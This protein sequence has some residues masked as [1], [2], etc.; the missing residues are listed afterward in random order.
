MLCKFINRDLLI[1]GTF[2]ISW[3]FFYQLDIFDQV[4][5]S[6]LIT[7]NLRWLF[8]HQSVEDPKVKESFV[9]RNVWIIP[10]LI[11]RWSLII[12]IRFSSR[13]K[14]GCTHHKSAQ[15]Q[16][17]WYFSK[18]HELR[19]RNSEVFGKRVLYF[20]KKGKSMEKTSELDLKQLN[21]LHYILI[22]WQRYSPWS[23]A[24]LVPSSA[25]GRW[26]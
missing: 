5:V 2:L 13:L 11:R 9:S 16:H 17:I 8:L 14:T 6:V 12:F 10:A 1:R 19:N 4:D 3:I 25:E 15:T 21:H 24:I 22:W 23:V 20:G 7:S 26:V 18:T